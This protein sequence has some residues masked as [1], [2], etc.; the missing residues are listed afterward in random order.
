MNTKGTSF[1]RTHA[2]P[3]RRFLLALLAALMGMSGCASPL[4]QLGG[5]VVPDARPVLT[6]SALTV[7]SPTMVEIE[8][9]LPTRDLANQWLS[10][11]APMKARETAIE[12]AGSPASQAPPAPTTPVTRECPNA[13]ERVLLIGDSLSAGLGLHVAKHARRCGTKLFVH[14]VVGSHVTE[15]TQ[16]SWL[17]AQLQRAK[18]TVVMVSLGGN[19]FMRND[20]R[21]VERAIAT[22]V[23]IV[24]E[25]GARLLW[26]SPP[27]MPFPDKVGV[28]DMWQGAIGSDM[29]IDWYPT[30][31]L[32]I[33]RVSDR[34]HPTISEYS[35]L[36][37]TLWQWMSTVTQ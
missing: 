5:P 33:P 4:A 1:S 34:V 28:R 24:R 8:R 35:K 3:S 10:D 30:E 12:G 27:T 17:K 18:P 32:K 16:P 21:N 9:H 6:P 36:S 2:R 23:S 26:I 15:W 14:G 19:D 13:E 31:Q 25:R 20:P 29:L 37:H 7:H 11:V 22:F